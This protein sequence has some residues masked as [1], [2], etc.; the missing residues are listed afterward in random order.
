MD[1]GKFLLKKNSEEKIKNTTNMI[2]KRKKLLKDFNKLGIL[3]VHQLEQEYSREFAE[4]V[5]NRGK[6][7]FEKIIPELP[8]LDLDTTKK[9]PYLRLFIFSAMTMS[10]Y[11]SLTYFLKDKKKAKQ[12]TVSFF[13]INLP[14]A[15]SF[16]IKILVMWMFSRFD[17]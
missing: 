12:L 4:R 17:K 5:F 10:I 16:P 15:T 14:I 6:M 8:F 13:Q 7:E 3:L 2:S 11:F 9:H 1:F